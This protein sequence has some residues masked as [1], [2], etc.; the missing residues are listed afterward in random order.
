MKIADIVSFINPFGDALSTA[1]VVLLVS[2]SILTTIWLLI[3]AK[4][5][6]WE[7]NWNGENLEGSASLD[8]DNGSVHDL[9]EAVATKAEQVADIMPGMLLI[10]GLLGTFVGLG[11]ALNSA[12][13]VLAS[14]NT[15]GMDTAMVNLMKLMEGLGAKFKTSTWGLLCFIVLNVLFNAFGFK[16]KRLAWAIQKVRSQNESK[17]AQLNQLENEKYEKLLS[18]LGQIGQQIQTD[19]Q[20]LLQFFKSGQERQESYQNQFLEQYIATNE[21]SQQLIDKNSQTQ[22]K[23]LRANLIAIQELQRQSQNNNNE[24][25]THLANQNQEVV[26]TLNEGFDKHIQQIRIDSQNNLDELKNI[27][28]SLSEGFKSN[29][30]QLQEDS[31]KSL[32]ELQK[33]ADYNEQTQKAMQNFVDKT[34][35]SM[36]SIGES[37]NKMGESAEAVG[38]SANDL[39]AVV[40]NLK[41]ELGDVM[42][43]I[44]KDL[45][46]TIGDMSE[47]FKENISQMSNSI[48]DNMA[49]M[50]NSMSN[51]TQGIENAV[52][53]LSVNVG[54]TMTE[55]TQTIG[56]SMDLQAKSANEFTITSDMLNGQIVEMTNL[57]QQLSGDIISG[58][59]AVSESGRRMQSLDKKFATNAEQVEEITQAAQTFAQTLTQLLDK[60]NVTNQLLMN[61]LEHLDRTI[62]QISQDINNSLQQIKPKTIEYNG[63]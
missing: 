51:A 1:F 2:L 57:V 16:E 46:E 43:M 40:Q 44:K 21:A 53:N 42:S 7:R 35:S 58:L 36:A 37:A 38:Q 17:N 18:I 29:L 59:K 19:N 34:V 32:I 54:D 49:Q 63:Q 9:S 15:S 28:H 12:S 10:I 24:L 4:A 61:V 30:S 56:K 48:Q 47:N 14:A 45:G 39:N 33:I 23:E 20:D 25:I 55:V 13:E 8:S 22:I 50:S 62:D 11:I 27:T 60:T 5:E 52:E 26:K 3:S 41:S 6:N 31:N